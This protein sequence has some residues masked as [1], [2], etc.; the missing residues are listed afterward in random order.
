MRLNTTPTVLSQKRILSKTDKVFW[1]TTL[2]ICVL[3]VEAILAAG[4]CAVTQS[5]LDQISSNWLGNTYVGVDMMLAVAAALVI[6][7]L[8]MVG[9]WLGHWFHRSE[10]SRRCNLTVSDS[11][12]SIVPAAIPPVC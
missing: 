11:G 7:D 5:L 1:V 4:A 6:A 10:R 3:L 12:D 9:L 2:M 8:A